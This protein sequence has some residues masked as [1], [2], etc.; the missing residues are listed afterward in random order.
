MSVK[1]KGILEGTVIINIL[2]LIFY[3][4]VDELSLKTS[5]LYKTFKKHRKKQKVENY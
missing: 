4:T 5:V 3:I 2:S 1:V